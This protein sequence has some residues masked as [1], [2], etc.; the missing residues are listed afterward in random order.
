MYCTYAGTIPLS[1]EY[2]QKD[3]GQH[4]ATKPP[5]PCVESQD[6]DTIYCGPSIFLSSY[7]IAPVLK[8]SGGLKVFGKV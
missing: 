6:T 8:W 7:L 4:N 5:D 3:K 1:G 2:I